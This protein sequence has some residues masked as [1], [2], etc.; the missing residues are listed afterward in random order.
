MLCIVLGQYDTKSAFLKGSLYP[1]IK[2]Y[3][4]DSLKTLS[5]KKLIIGVHQVLFL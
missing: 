1:I 2:S 4:F 3:Y 5:K